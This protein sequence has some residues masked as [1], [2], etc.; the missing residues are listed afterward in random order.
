MFLFELIC[1]SKTKLENI[2]QSI[3]N[4]SGKGSNELITYKEFTKV[5]SFRTTML[6]IS[7]LIFSM[8]GISIGVAVVGVRLCS[9][10]GGRHRCVSEIVVSA[11]VLYQQIYLWSCITS[12]YCCLLICV[13][14]LWTNRTADIN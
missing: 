11:E 9:R 7:I 12:A 13:S 10:G 1:N 14:A 6:V 8:Y 2:V 5:L 4:D 3:L